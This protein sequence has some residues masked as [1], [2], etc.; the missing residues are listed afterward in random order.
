MSD[1]REKV[2]E[3]EVAALEER[4]KELASKM[5]ELLGVDCSFGACVFDPELTEV[6]HKIDEVQKRKKT[7]EQIMSDVE[8]CET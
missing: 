7:L 6:E 4:T 2:L 1:D 8:K 5:Q 3:D